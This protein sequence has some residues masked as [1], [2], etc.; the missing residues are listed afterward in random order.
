MTLSPKNGYGCIQEVQCAAA[1]RC[2][3]FQKLFKWEDTVE[4]EIPLSIEGLP[5]QTLW[6]KKVLASVCRMMVLIPTHS[7]EQVDKTYKT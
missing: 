4:K 1:I 2:Q 6:E 5:D 3:C 7:H